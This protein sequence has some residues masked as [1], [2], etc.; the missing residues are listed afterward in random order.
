MLTDL[1][2]IGTRT[3]VEGFILEEKQAV[4]S[5]AL[6]IRNAVIFDM[7]FKEVEARSF[8]EEFLRLYSEELHKAM[9]YRGA[10]TKLAISP[11]SCSDVV[12]KAANEAGVE[13]KPNRFSVFIMAMYIGHGAF[14][15]T[16]HVTVYDQNPEEQMVRKKLKLSLMDGKVMMEETE[17][18]NVEASFWP[19]G[20]LYEI[21]KE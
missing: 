4:Q 15:V 3:H 5:V 17:D 10:E 18:G 8:F 21:L 11:G 6:W 16:K 13:I 1:C 12:Q 2:K 9:S 14:N 19:N 20:N 7:G